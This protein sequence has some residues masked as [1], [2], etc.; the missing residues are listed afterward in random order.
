MILTHGS[1]SISR[2]EDIDFLFYTDFTNYDSYTLTDTPLVGQSGVYG[3]T[4]GHTKS[5][6]LYPQ[7]SGGPFNTDYGSIQFS[8]NF[9]QM[10]TR[11]KTIVHKS[12]FDSLTGEVWMKGAVNGAYVGLFGCQTLIL[13]SHI[14]LLMD[15]WDSTNAQF[16]IYNGASYHSASSAT[17]KYVNA[18]TANPANWNHISVVYTQTSIYAYVNGTLYTSITNQASRMHTYSNSRIAL[19]G[20]GSSGITNL[21][22]LS[23]R[24]GDKSTNDHQTFPVPTAPYL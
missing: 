3:S 19:N 8:Y 12:K 21:G 10:P 22:Y 2:G 6:L 17:Q 14:V 9:A 15:P 4:E 7:T 1:N 23:W 20:T 24:V 5:I 13:E 11:Y 16:N 18:P